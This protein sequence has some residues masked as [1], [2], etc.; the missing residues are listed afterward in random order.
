MDSGS[1]AAYGV[2][3]SIFRARKW[4]TATAA[5]ACLAAAAGEAAEM[6]SHQAVYRLSL[7]TSTAA[8]GIKDAGGAMLYRFADT[9]DGWS[10][11]NRTNMR[12]TTEEGTIDSEWNF[13]SWE[14]RDGKAYRFHVQQLRDG[15]TS[16]LLTGDAELSEK[17]GTARFKPP[18]DEE[19]ELAP[20][21]LFPTQHLKELLNAATAGTRR[22]NRVVFDGATEDNPYEINAVVSEVSPEE[23][24]EAASA[25]GLP[26][27]R[28]WRIHLAFFPAA[29]QSEEPEFEL[30]VRYRDD[31][32]AD[33]LEQDFGKF[34]LKLKI[35]KFER[36]PD[37]G[38]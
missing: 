20:G 17:G 32:I 28:T 10:A 29:T 3:M 21:T 27:T 34:S 9:C 26:E 7:G 36:L 35:A 15:K 31:G 16:E 25:I 19:I 24:K 11:E 37:P 30:A 22:F 1:R 23:R 4:V 14:A 38:C 12:L 33:E 2:A 8:S 18:Q 6:A 13:V 5:M